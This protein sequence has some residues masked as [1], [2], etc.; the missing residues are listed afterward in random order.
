MTNIEQLERTVKLAREQ[1]DALDNI[2]PRIQSGIVIDL[3]SPE[4]NVFFILGICNRLAKEYGISDWK[5]P[6]YNEMKYED[7]LDLCQKQFGLIY[8]NRH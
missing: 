2:N 3:K 6:H 7:I 8:L 4:G 1:Q 5:S